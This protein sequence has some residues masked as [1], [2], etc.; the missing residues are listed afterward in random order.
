[1]KRHPGLKIEVGGHTNLRPGDRFANELSSN[2]AHTVVRYLTD[3]GVAAGRVTYKGYG[4]SRPRVEA[5]S[6]EADRAN[7]RVEVKVL[8][9]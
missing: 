2:R 6:K 4:K 5:V 3:N 1:M 8:E 9:K 7:Q